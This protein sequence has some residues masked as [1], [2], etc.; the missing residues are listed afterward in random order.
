MQPST[1]H[2]NPC[3]LLPRVD[4]TP[5]RLL[6]VE[7]ASVTKIAYDNIELLHFDPNDEE[8]LDEQSRLIDAYGATAQPDLPVY[9]NGRGNVEWLPSLCRKWRELQDD[10]LAHVVAGLRSARLRRLNPLFVR[11]LN[12]TL[13][14]AMAEVRHRMARAQRVKAYAT[15][16]YPDW[17]SVD[18]LREVERVTRASGR[19]V[20]AEFVFACPFHEDTHPSF[21]VHPGKQTW[22]CRAQCGGGGVVDFLKRIRAVAA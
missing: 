18:L 14:F 10:D 15:S 7:V 17:R 22:I 19:R 9:I 3:G 2:H 6:L 13:G 12:A 1:S 4:A 8:R 11:S 16:K 21:Y 5:G 20:G